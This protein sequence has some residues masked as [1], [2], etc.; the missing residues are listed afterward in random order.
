MQRVLT[1][2]VGPGT[3]RREFR[4]VSF[5]QL[6]HHLKYLYFLSI[7]SALLIIFAV[8]ITQQNALLLLLLNLFY[9]TKYV[10]VCL[11]VLF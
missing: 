6:K 7:M 11:R 1:I 4:S 3:K 8:F 9:T 2:L 5:L 10:R